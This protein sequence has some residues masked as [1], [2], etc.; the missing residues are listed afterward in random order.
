MLGAMLA[1]PILKAIDNDVENTV[2]TYIPNTS[3]VAF[4]GLYA[5]IEKWLDSQKKEKILKFN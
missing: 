3:T 5:E 2:F 1:E 4:L